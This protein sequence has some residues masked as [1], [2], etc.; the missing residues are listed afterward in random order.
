MTI[1]L[2]ALSAFLA[3]QAAQ[4]YFIGFLQNWT[5]KGIDTGTAVR[6]AVPRTV[7]TK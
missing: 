3:A 1:R 7:C 6:S 5:P 2:I 4:L